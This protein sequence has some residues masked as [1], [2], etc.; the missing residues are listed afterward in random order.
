[1]R[2]AYPFT[3]TEPIAIKGIFPFALEA[4]VLDTKEKE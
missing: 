4:P 3:T 1:L 2:A